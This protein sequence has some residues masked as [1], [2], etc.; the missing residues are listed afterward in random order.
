MKL[1]V[2]RE[3]L[4]E[5]L[6]LVS[7]AVSS[8]TAVLV[9]GGIQLRAVDGELHLAATDMELS[10]RSS[11][12]ADVAGE[13]EVVVPGRL[14]LDIARSLP[15]SEVSIEHAA[16]ESLLVLTCGSASYRIHTYSA[17]DFPRLPEIDVSRLQS[18][19]RDALVET[20]ARVGR[21]ASRDESRPVLTGILVR[22]EPGKIVMAATDSYRLAVKETAAESSLPELEAIIPARALQ[23]LSRLDVSDLQLG[24]YE[25]HVV[26]GSEGTWLTTRRIDGQ[27]PN[28][29]QLLPEQ[30][31]H[32]LQLPREEL[33]DV[34]RRVSVMA[35]RN[36]PLRLRFA[37]GELTVS[38]QTQ[39]VGE[40]RESLP[41]AFV[42]DVLEIG[43]NADFLRDGLESVDASTVTLK[44]IS[45]LRPA[46]LEG[47]TADYTYLIMPIRLAG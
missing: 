19:D 22:F 12:E 10:L 47:E 41:A 11:V 25:N 38:A 39:D 15:E 27:F 4:L 44:L 2:S 33:L 36:S 45:P 24:V 3:A 30:F 40:A 26:F 5:K 7:R 23:E 1:S 28:Y 9:L 21:S 18:V 37:D 35:Q 17:E 6:G 14:L 31:E 13:G 16:G 43:F 34:V 29:R 20:V 8:R 46:V 32:T 42:G